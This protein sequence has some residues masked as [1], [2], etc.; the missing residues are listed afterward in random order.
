MPVEVAGVVGMSL[1]SVGNLRVR[2]QGG[3]GFSLKA[4]PRGLGVWGLLKNTPNSNSP[5]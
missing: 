1:R 4:W 2:A 5:L 3:L